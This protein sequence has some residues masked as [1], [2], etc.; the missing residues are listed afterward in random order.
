MPLPV[1][2]PVQPHGWWRRFRAGRPTT[3][4]PAWTAGWSPP[5]TV[6]SRSGTSWSVSRSWRRSRRDARRPCT[7]AHWPY[8]VRGRPAKWNRRGSPITRSV[9]KTGPPCSHTRPSRHN[10]HPRWG[11]TR[12]PRHTSAARSTCPGAGRTRTGPDSW[13]NLAG[14]VIWPT[15]STAP[16]APGRRPSR[17]GGRL[18]T[19]VGGAGRWS[20]WRSPRRTWPGRSRSA[21][22]PAMKHS[23]CWRDSHRDP[24]MHSPAPSAASSPQWRSTTLTPSRGASGSSPW[25]A[26]AP[27]RWIGRSRCC[28]S[29]SAGPRTATWPAST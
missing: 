9:L 15:T 4:M 21:R 5:M 18:A 16:C 3:S 28:R 11:L 20:G 2:G 8:S 10:G 12:R 17:R 23:R 1:S 7:G 27:D 22:R 14:S 13:K 29:E 24:S 25:P 26:R 19:T 6:R